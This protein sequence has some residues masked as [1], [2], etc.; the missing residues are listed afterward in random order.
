[1]DANTKLEWFSPKRIMKLYPG[2]KARFGS[3]RLYVVGIGANGADCLI[4]C[5]DIAENRYSFDKSSVRFLGIGLQERLDV[6]ENG[7]VL[8]P[9]ERLEIDPEEAV[10]PYLNDPEKIPA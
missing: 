6:S 4:K 1:M 10:Y 2:E 3:R 8:D 7:S 5:K 9:D